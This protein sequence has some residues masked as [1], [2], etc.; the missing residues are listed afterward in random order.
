MHR[1]NRRNDH[2]PAFLI[3]SRLLGPHNLLV[4]SS[5]AE[6][7]HAFLGEVRDAYRASL[8]P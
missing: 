2:W 7:H 1:Y 4:L 5:C 6:L 8:L 3:Y